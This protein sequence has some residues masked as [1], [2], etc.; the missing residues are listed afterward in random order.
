[1]SLDASKRVE[2]MIRDVYRSSD[3]M[4]ET[5]DQEVAKVKKNQAI[6]SDSRKQY[7]VI[8]KTVSLTSN[9]IRQIVDSTGRQSE[10]TKEIAQQVD[11]ITQVAEETASSTEEVA[12]AVEEL[13]A[14]LQEL[15][16][17][18]NDLAD[19]AKELSELGRSVS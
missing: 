17:G 7:E 18:A 11:I 1:S 13:T 2:E 16:T 12:A 15:T 14:S 3:A 4:F 19:L 5:V 10:E 9:Q 8:A 6:T